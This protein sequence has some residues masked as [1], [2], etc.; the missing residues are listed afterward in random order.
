MTE[1]GGSLGD[2]L[3]MLPIPQTGIPSFTMSGTVILKPAKAGDVT[4]KDTLHVISIGG[5]DYADIGLTG[6]FTK[7]DSATTSLID[8]LSPI[9][10]YSSTFGS[11]FDFAAGFNKKGSETKNGVDS[12]FYQ[13]TDAGSAALAELGSVAG[14]G[15]LTWT[16]EIWVAKK[17]GYPVSMTITAS[18]LATATSE[19]S[20]MYARSFDITKVN[21]AGNK[22][23]APTNVTGA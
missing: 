17:G 10:V 23:T 19:A 5:F 14:L 22:V 20:V 1:T 13:A 6:A 18:S 8:S 15:D 12:D 16:G 7:N 3:S 11:S 9:A 4:V 21:D 2:T